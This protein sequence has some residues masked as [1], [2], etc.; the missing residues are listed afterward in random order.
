MKMDEVWPQI[1]GETEEEREIEDVVKYKRES[2][3]TIAR[4]LNYVNGDE[5]KM[6]I[7]HN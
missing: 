3:C 4:Y 5:L 7:F 2:S 1:V 6:I